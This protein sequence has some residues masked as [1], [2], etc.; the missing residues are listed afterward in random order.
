MAA[1]VTRRIIVT[2]CVG[3][4]LSHALMATAQ[5][6]SPHAIDIPPWFTESFLDL[7]DEAAAAAR[8]GKR[9]MVY[10]GQD[11]CPYCRELMTNSFSQKP[12]VEKTR[13]HFVAIAL[14]LWG[15]REVTWIDGRRM[16]EK[17]FARL[18]KVQFT[19]SLLF[20]DGTG[21]IVARLNGYHPPQRMS[22]V[23]DYVAGQMENRLSLSEHLAA[24]PPDTARPSLN[25]QPFFMKPPFDLARRA[26]SRPLAVIFETR[27]CQACD[28]MHSQGLQRAEVRAQLPRFDVARFALS[29]PTEIV[30][31]TGQRRSA[32][33][34]ARELGVAYTPTWVFFDADA[35]EVFRVDGY[36]RPFHLATSLEYVSSGAYRGE[37]EF[38]RYIRAKA[39][40]L[41]AAGKPVELWK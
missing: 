29:D 23:L 17:E 16:S 31:P 21:R 30:T 39:E 36:L 19:P 26:G 5:V 37:P 25:D 1:A 4:A 22:A 35:R 2:L 28:E 13:M 18:M 9:L 33:A 34:W 7:K 11:G 27:S 6:A 32:A 20:M 40:R 3:W 15:D 24:L 41:R 38:Q 8:D 10:F 14:N 12:I